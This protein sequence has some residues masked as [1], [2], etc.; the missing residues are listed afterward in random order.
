M[1]A[2]LPL[3]GFSPEGAEI[4]GTIELLAVGSEGCLLI[5]HK[6]GGKGEG[7]SYYWPQLKSYGALVESRFP[8]HP[9]KGLAVFWIDHTRLELADPPFDGGSPE[10][11]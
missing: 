11:R 2:E 5:D 9:L 10:A 6:S 7:S 8:Q 4:P 3:L 1:R